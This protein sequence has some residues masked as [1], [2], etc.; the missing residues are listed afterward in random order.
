MKSFELRDSSF[1]TIHQS[2]NRLELNNRV[3]KLR[4]DCKYDEI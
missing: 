3:A 1:R 2:G 4:F